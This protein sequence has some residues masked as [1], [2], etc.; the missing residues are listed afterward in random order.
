MLR[1]TRRKMDWIAVVAILAYGSGF[2]LAAYCP[3][4]APMRQNWLNEEGRF[5]GSS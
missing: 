1:F 4:S 2:S 5:S 3:A